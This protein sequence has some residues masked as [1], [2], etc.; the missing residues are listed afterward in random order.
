MAI[1]YLT[2]IDLSQNELLR[3]RL[4]NYAGNPAVSPI[5]PG[6]E[7][8]IIWDSVND[9]L[10]I[11]N[12]TSWGSV[13]TKYSI[14]SEA[15]TGVA[16]LRLTGTNGVTDDVTFQGDSTI[17]ISRAGA[18]LINIV[19]GTND[20]QLHVPAVG[21]TNNGKYL[22]AGSAAGVMTW[23][24]INLGTDTAGNYVAGLTAGT[25]VSINN[26]VGEGNT[27][28]ISIG[29]SVAPADTVTFAGATLGSIQVGVT[30]ETTIAAT[31]GS[32][33]LDSLDGNVYVDD[34]LL[35]QGNLTVNGTVTTVNTQTINLADNI[36]TLNS[37][38]TGTPTQNGGIEVERGT[39]PNAAILWNESIDRWTFTNDGSTYHN[40]AL[41]TEYTY[42]A[43]NGIGLTD[44]T[45]FVNAGAGL[46]QDG[47]G[48][49]HADTSTLS[50]IQGSTGVSS[51][52]VDS[53]GHVTGV[54]TATY[55]R[56]F[57]ADLTTSANEYILTH[58][59]G[60]QDAQVT[61]RETEAPYA[62]V[63]TDVEFTSINTVTI[64]FNA[65]PTAGKYRVV[66]IG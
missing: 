58:N 54:S 50:G 7:G 15:G 56:R 19:H 41:P 34:N 28:T 4:E 20:G 24:E 65:A 16:I 49:S 25:G 48:L 12:G 6:L 64:K 35:V 53:F 42:Y 51:I 18:S 21:T 13:D 5:V 1:K 30:T 3:P 60:T 44:K 33:H 66:V 52:T 27:A 57:A 29:Q 62:Q 43:G 36:I 61:I 2:S 26:P 38:E 40:I 47:D 8:Q 55:M 45:F 22:R 23:D 32:L 9:N 14:S 17:S 37:D 10:M 59:L 11:H 31:T 46:V 39:L 63:F